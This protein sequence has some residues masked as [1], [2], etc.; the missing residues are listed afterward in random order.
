[1]SFITGENGVGN[2]TIQPSNNVGAPSFSITGNLTSTGAITYIPNGTIDLRGYTLTGTNFTANAGANTGNIVC[3]TGSTSSAITLTNG[4]Y[5]WNS[6]KLN[7]FSNVR[8]NLSSTNTKYVNGGG[9]TT[10]GKV[11]NTGTGTLVLQNSDTFADLTMNASPST[12]TFTTGKT[13]TLTNFHPSGSAGSLIAINSSTP[14][15]QANVTVTNPVSIDYVTVQDIKAL[16]TTWYAGTNS[17][18][19]GDNT[20]VIFSGGGGS[21]IKG[22]FF[23]F[24]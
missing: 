21:N 15:V 7:M 1:M 2:L 11:Y 12:L 23:L 16:L 14:G 10:F 20:N 9:N 24:F 8:I 3:T 17:T 18:D 4:D 5:V 13:P 6:Q 22:Q 19:L